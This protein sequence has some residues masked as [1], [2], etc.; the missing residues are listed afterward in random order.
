M[1]DNKKKIFIR[2]VKSNERG[3]GLT[4]TI[5][6]PD[7]QD[8]VLGEWGVVCYGS[9]FDTEDTEVIEMYLEKVKK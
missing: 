7:G 2:S 8:L 9:I 5:T 6:G 4:I 3:D 1:S